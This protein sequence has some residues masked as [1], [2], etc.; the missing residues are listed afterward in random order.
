MK[1]IV[2]LFRGTRELRLSPERALAEWGQHYADHLDNMW[3]IFNNCCSKM[4]LERS[5]VDR[6]V[7][8][9]Y[10]W[11]NSEHSLISL[12]G[13]PLI[14]TDH[15]DHTD[16]AEIT[17]DFVDLVYNVH[18]ELTNYI[19]E[20]CLPFLKDRYSSYSQLCLLLK[21]SDT[22]AGWVTVS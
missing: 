15:T 12:Y 21:E 3:R 5:S 19:E 10:V 14:L 18:W 6:N 1:T 2:R 16:P 22:D 8:Y 4:N 17:Q 13:T 9:E 20:E 11:Y 7:F